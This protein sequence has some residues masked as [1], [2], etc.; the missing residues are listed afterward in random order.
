MDEDV[1]KLMEI[2]GGCEKIRNTRLARSYRTF[3]RQCVFMYLLSL[4]WGI[5]HD[6]NWWT[7]PLSAMIS[8]FMLG[9]E[10]AAEHTEEPFGEDEDDLDQAGA[11]RWVSSAACQ[12]GQAKSTGVSEGRVLTRWCVTMSAPCASN[13]RSAASGSNWPRSWRGKSRS[14][15]PAPANKAS[16][17]TLKKTSALA[18]LL[19][20]FS[21]DTHSGSIR[22][23]ITRGVSSVQTCATDANG[24][25]AKPARCHAKD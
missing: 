13:H 10:I 2:V 7:V 8:Y 5:V 1:R 17:K 9:M 24:A 15:L 16:D 22:S 11:K 21:A 6:F 25:Q 14:L 4:P 12:A 20:M 18:C 3:A 19:S 23:C